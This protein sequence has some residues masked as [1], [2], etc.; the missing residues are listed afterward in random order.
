MNDKVKIKLLEPCV[1]NKKDEP[2][3]ATPTVSAREARYLIGL[4][5]AVAFH[6]NDKAAR[7]TRS[8]D[9]PPENPKE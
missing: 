2:I 9:E 7:S 6:G 5:K 3:G 4:G 1:V 8:G